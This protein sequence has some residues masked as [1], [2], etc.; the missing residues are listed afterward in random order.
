MVKMGII[1]PLEEYLTKFQIRY[2]VYKDTIPEPTSESIL[3]PVEIL[4][5]GK[6]DSIIALVEEALSTLQKLS[7][8]WQLT[9]VKCLIIN[10][11]IFLIK[12]LFP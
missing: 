1:N 10:F 3:E 11:L 6:F 4:K 12:N 2:E 9:E 5:H 8:H 7:V